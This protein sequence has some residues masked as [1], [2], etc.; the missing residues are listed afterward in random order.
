MPKSIRNILI[1]ASLL[2]IAL[3]L[4][5]FYYQNIASVAVAGSALLLIII[6]FPIIHSHEKRMQEQLDKVLVENAS[7]AAKLI[8][9]V[10]VPCMIFSESGRI[11][12]RNEVMKRLYSGADIKSLPEVCN[13]KHRNQSATMEYSNGSYHVINMPIE[14]EHASKKLIFQYW[15]NRTE[16]EHYRRLFEEQMPCVALV[17]VDNFEELNADSQFYRNTV[18]TEV[19]RLISK[20]ANDVEG[21]YR[22]YD[23]ARFIVV[24]ETRY[25]NKLEENRFPLLEQA[26]SIDTG[27]DQKISLSIAVGAASRIA[28][29]D[30]DARK[31]M[32][33]ALGRGGGQA[34]IKTGVNYKFYG[35]R[36]QMESSQSRV[37]ARLFAKALRQIFENSTE[38]FIMGHKQSDMDCFGAALGLARCASHIGCRAHIVLDQVNSTIREAVDEIR[39]NSAY[40]GLL[41]TPENAGLLM[42]P[43]SILIVVDTQRANSTIAPQLLEKSE[44]IVLID[45]HRRSADYIDNSTLNY[46]EIRASSTSEMVTEIMQ[47]FDDNLRPMAFECSALL[48]G[49]TV[50]T[51]HFSFN[52]GAR[53]FEAAAYLRQHGA[54]ISMVKQ[55]FQN[56]KD[57]YIAR[58][59]TVKNAETICPGVAISACMAPKDA[60]LVAAQAADELITIRGT[61]AAFV[62][63]KED[64]DVSISGRS[65][66]R[67]NV[68]IVLELMGGGGHLT[69]AGA[70]LKDVSVEEAYELL[71]NTV[72]SYMKNLDE[73][74]QS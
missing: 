30:E 13:P 58:V 21:V 52:T 67:I 48:A 27:T 12:W 59:N 7:A 6:S 61:D 14:R 43:S 32:E 45:H 50:D 29:A 18:L 28:Q 8:S 19:E 42:R 24:F 54:D 5:L 2:C 23:N 68:Q 22:K 1:I 74:T 55:M 36:R 3:C 63:G 37:R 57:S 56:D 44:K 47:Y 31:A 71:K 26:H 66:G 35:G 25:L 46:L 49:I 41:Q 65:L 38:V 4:Y 64:K 9:L 72:M 70:Q 11:I 10:N 51:K 69:M 39:V 40:S 34:V 53:T 17:Y 73:Q 62:L 60:A 20:M 15:I 33:L 16:A